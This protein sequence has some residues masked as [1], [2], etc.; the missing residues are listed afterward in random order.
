MPNSI[1]A[2]V[3]TVRRIANFGVA[4]GLGFKCVLHLIRIVW[5]TT[6]VSHTVKVTVVRLSS[7]DRKI[8][9]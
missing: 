6:A 3:S 1:Q 5:N 8:Y 2:K 4:V 9:G 7:I